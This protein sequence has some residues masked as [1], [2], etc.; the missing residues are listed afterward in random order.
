MKKKHMESRKIPEV[1][2]KPIPKLSFGKFKDR[3]LDEV[4][5]QYLRWALKKGFLKGI[6]RETAN[7]LLGNPVSEGKFPSAG[8]FG[9]E[10]ERGLD[11][12]FDCPEDEDERRFINM[13]RSF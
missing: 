6:V 4:P 5:P 12:P 13:V 11:C 9:P 8:P 7:R 1:Q 3:P 2:K 10:V